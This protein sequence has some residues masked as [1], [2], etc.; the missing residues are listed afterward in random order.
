MK[1]FKGILAV[2]MIVLLF[3]CE[4]DWDKHYTNNPPTVDQN[5][6]EAIQEN[7]ELS[8][9]VQYMRDMS[10]DTLFEKDDTYTLFI[11]LNSA[12]NSLPDTAEV[13]NTIM[14][15]HISSFY[16]QAIDIRG[17]RKLQTLGEKY[18]L[19]ERIGDQSKFDEIPVEFESPLYKN[20]KYYTLGQVAEPKP[21]LYEFFSR[22]NPVLQRY[23]DEQ[24][25]IIL[26]RE[27]SRP[28]GFDEF[29]NTIYDTVSIIYNEFEEFFFPV[30]EEFRNKTATIVF[31]KTE[32][33]NNALTEMAQTLGSVY[34]DYR[35]IPQEWQDEILVPYLL[36][37][38]VFQNMLEPEEFMKALPTDTV[39]LKNILGD[40]VIIDYIPTEKT[41]CSNGYAYNY[42]D[43]QIPDTLYTGSTR[44]EGEWLLEE[45][46]I[47]RFAWLEEVDVVSDQP[48]LPM[49]EY[50]NTASNDSILRVPFN[51]G[52]SGDFSVSFR[53]DNLFP[54]N[55]LMVVRTHMYVGGIYDIYVN[56]ELVKTV[57]YY[58]YVRNREL[59]WSVTGKR[60]IPEGGFNRWDCFVNNTA[61]YGKA[62][63]RFE[64]KDPAGVLSNGLVIDYIEFIPYDE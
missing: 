6:W 56:D 28:I 8:S 35:D 38:G 63:V 59:Y 24:D 44:M 47:N 50:V 64:Y 39:K 26:D 58:D 48:F 33:Y 19:F 23:I 17:K 40:S 5:L 32:D 41:L 11:P 22:N 60:Y 2:A 52:Y 25:S 13:S 27:E 4:E 37:Y 57:D 61:D 34:I 15:Y 21:N 20:G 1:I 16:V 10:Y 42:R 53:V 29:G 45:A 46:G 55:Y 7:P 12:F 9:F 31:P 54:R 3:S 36:E 18:A 49:R 62:E 51:K 14:D 43:F 30:R